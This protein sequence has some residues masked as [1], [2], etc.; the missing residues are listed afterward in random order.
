VTA[1][2]PPPLPW[3]TC[4]RTRPSDW[5]WAWRRKRSPNASAGSG[6]R[7]DQRP[8]RADNQKEPAAVGPDR[9]ASTRPPLR[10]VR[11]IVL[12]CLDDDAATE[13]IDSWRAISMRKFAAANPRPADE[14]R[15]PLRIVQSGYHPGSP[16]GHSGR[17]V[18][19]TCLHLRD[20]LT[21]GTDSSRPV[22][23]P[24]RFLPARA[25]PPSGNSQPQ[26]RPPTGH[27]HFLLNDTTLRHRT[28]THCTNS[29][30]SCWAAT[31]SW[32]GGRPQAGGPARLTSVPHRQGTSSASTPLRRNAMPGP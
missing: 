21:A 23:T 12:S 15:P 17:A 10:T 4:S 19:A 20:W 5:S 6:A 32:C 1:A 22:R 30:T 16:A 29:C 18:H 7:R 9:V 2:E 26:E 14:G 13:W 24:L 25:P 27:A 31:A 11:L 3:Q 28:N 8:H